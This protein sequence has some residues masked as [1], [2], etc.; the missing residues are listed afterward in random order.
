MFVGLSSMRKIGIIAR[1][2]SPLAGAAVNDLVEWIKGRGMIVL[3]DER[4]AGIANMGSSLSRSDV[5]AEAD[6]LVVLGGDGTF[7]AVAHMTHLRKVPLLGI[8]LGSLGFLAEF[9]IEEMIP[10][11]ENFLEGRLVFEDR[12][13][14]DICV[15]RNGSEIASHTALNDIVIH[16]AAQARMLR[17]RVEVDGTN[18]NEYTADGL[19]L[20][21]PTGST[22]YNL[23]AGGPIVH[24]ALGAIILSPVCPHTLSNRPVVLPDSVTID[25]I[26]PEKRS[27]EAV[28]SFDGQV[29]YK[30][31]CHDRIRIK[32]SECCTRIVL[33]EKRNYFELLRGKL[34]W[35]GALIDAE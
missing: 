8:N 12:N 17:V 32:K 19:I 11:M 14:L 20:A 16:R 2:R 7:L 30:L 3:M 33:S 28:A 31:G 15:F 23:S 18:V 1:T 26:L 22:A 21:T 6:L 13:M 10:A 27:S 24:P 5:A 4:S 29:S 35:G 34:K 9:S 25:L